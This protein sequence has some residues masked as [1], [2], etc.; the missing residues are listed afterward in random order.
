MYFIQKNKKEEKYTILLKTNLLIQTI[1]Y[2]LYK[3]LKKKNIFFILLID[4]IL[5]WFMTNIHILQQYNFV[6]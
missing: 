2:L 6:F 5:S 4:F 3:I 1:H